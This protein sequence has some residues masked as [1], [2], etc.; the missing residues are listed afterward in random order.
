MSKTESIMRMLLLAALFGTTF[1]G[2]SAFGQGSF[3]HHTWC[4]RHGSG[5]ECAFDSLQQCTEGKHS[6]TDSC[7]QNSGTMNH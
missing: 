3:S 7:F 2:S 1:A 6:N 4:L 5:Q